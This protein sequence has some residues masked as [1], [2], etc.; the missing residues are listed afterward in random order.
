MAQIFRVVAQNCAAQLASATALSSP[1]PA[2]STSTSISAPQTT[3]DEVP[4]ASGSNDPQSSKR[5]ADVGLIVGVVL[6]AVG[7]ASLLTALL[8]WWRHRRRMEPITGEWDKPFHVSIQFMD[9]WARI[10]TG[11]GFRGWHLAIHLFERFWQRVNG[12]TFLWRNYRF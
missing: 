3:T 5:R 1:V 11:G 8:L 2:S 9:D 4:G 7:G 10:R 12:S 6:G